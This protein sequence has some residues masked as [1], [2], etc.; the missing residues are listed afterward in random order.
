[1]SLLK[2]GREG[3]IIIIIIV[4]EG[5]NPFGIC[6]YFPCHYFREGTMSL[7]LQVFFEVVPYSRN[8]IECEGWRRHSSLIFLVLLFTKPN[9]EVSGCF[10]SRF[11]PCI[12]V[13]TTTELTSTTKCLHPSHS[14]SNIHLSI[15]ITLTVMLKC[16]KTVGACVQAYNF[17][18]K[19]FLITP[20]LYYNVGNLI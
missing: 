19:T 5:V 6:H 7:I 4:R 15:G 10:F 9:I 20:V 17:Q 3:V 8:I 11:S 18:I 13:I 14:M 16:N 2:Q 12:G 1:M